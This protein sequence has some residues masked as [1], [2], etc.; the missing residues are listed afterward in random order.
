[1]KHNMGR[2][3]R[4]LRALAAVVLA[5]LVLSGS[6]GGALAVVLGVL[7]VMLLGTSLLGY[8]PPYALLGIS[9]C[10]CEEHRKP[11]AASA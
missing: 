3:D 7:A 5:Y 8:C 1:M 11:P 6:V 2:V 4:T 9:T 10:K